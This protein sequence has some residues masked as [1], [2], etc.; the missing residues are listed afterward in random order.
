MNQ[1]AQIFRRRLISPLFPGNVR[2]LLYILLCLLVSCT[3]AADRKAA[4]PKTPGVTDTEIIL[5]T[6]LALSGHASF[7]G[8][9][10]LHG[11]LCYIKSVNEHGGVHG[12]KIRVKFYDDG[13][14]PPRCLAN[15]QRLIVK[16]NVFCLICYVGTSTSAK[17]LPIVK[18]VKVPLL[19]LFTGAQILRTPFQRYIINIRASYHQEIATV[20]KELAGSLGIKKFAVFY[21]YDDY[22]FDGLTGT[23]IALKRYG[24]EPVVAASYRRGSLD[25]EDGLGRILAS[26]AEAVVMI[27]TYEPCAKFIYLARARGFNPLFHC[28]S[29]VGAD[30]LLEKLGHSGE[31]VIITQVVPPPTETLL[32]P[33]AAEYAELLARFYPDDKPNYVGFEGFLNAKVL[34]EGLRRS[35]RRLTREGFI[36]GIET[37]NNFSLGIANPLSFSTKDHQGLEK[38]YL[39]RIHKGR[40]VLVTNLAE[41]KR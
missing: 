17:I 22:G 26:G 1:S 12:R 23:Q 7:L 33:A 25:V 15:T 37:I 19:G 18:E 3:K 36:A 40:L 41:I 20:V 16:D 6:S 31:G 13:Y 27:G 32:L 2:H 8:T 9:R 5:G 28:V 34:V 11:A 10:T 24:L 29:F 39:T 21:Q 38:V 30:E 14:D 35:Y 4:S